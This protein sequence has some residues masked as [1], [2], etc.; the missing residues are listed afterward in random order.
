MKFFEFANLGRG[1]QEEIIFVYRNK[2]E[3]LTNKTIYDGIITMS[4]L[5]Y[6]NFMHWMEIL[7]ANSTQNDRGHKTDERGGMSLCL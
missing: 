2:G 5:F 7:E 6:N 3:K 4:C 1:P